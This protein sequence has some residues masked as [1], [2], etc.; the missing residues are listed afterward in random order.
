M[1]R[2]QER[3]RSNPKARQAKC[4]VGLHLHKTRMNGGNLPLIDEPSN[5]LGIEIHRALSVS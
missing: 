2:K 1:N 4:K 3:A 5:D